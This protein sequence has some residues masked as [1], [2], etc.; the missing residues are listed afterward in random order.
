M[1]GS[2]D[3]FISYSHNDADWV[4]SFAER[5]KNDG[6]DVAYDELFLLPGDP[7]V[8]KIEQTVRDSTHGLLVYS[9]AAAASRW[10][11][12]EY[13]AMLGQA[14]DDPDRRLIPVLVKDV[15]LPLFARNRYYLDFRKGITAE[16]DKLLMVLRR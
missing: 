14:I 16:Y 6:I 4:R 10:V 2:Y 13:Q 5:L 8:H 9:P 7:L 12:E 3:V 11:G 1:A 15:E